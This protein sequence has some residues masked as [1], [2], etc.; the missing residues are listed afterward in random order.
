MNASRKKSH[1]TI[2]RSPHPDLIGLEPKL[3]T[4]AW[5]SAGGLWF[6][7]SQICAVSESDIVAP[8]AS[9]NILRFQIHNMQGIAG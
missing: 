7:I 8:N 2:T 3:T 1:L 9:T 4:T 5:P 6:T